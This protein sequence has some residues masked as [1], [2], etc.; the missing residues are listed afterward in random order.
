MDAI[1][2]TLFSSE[3]EE[4]FILDC[5]SYLMMFMAFVTFLALLFVNVPYGRYASSR[6]GFPVNVKIAWFIQ[7]LPAFLL[8]LALILSTCAKITH[9]PN[10]LLLLM[11][12]CHYT[13]R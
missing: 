10:Q 11:Y 2:K 1:L 6:Y 8:P 3:D 7:E 5:L 4:L 12:F 13:Q 9:L